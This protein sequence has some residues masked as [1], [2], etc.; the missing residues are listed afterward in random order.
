MDIP[1]R[2]VVTVLVMAATITAGAAFID[3]LGREA[4]AANLRA[5]AGHLAGEVRRLSG[6][7]PFSAVEVS[8]RLEGVGFASIEYLDVGCGPV[9]G[10]ACTALRG[11]LEGG[12]EEWF[13][14]HDS[15]GR[16][17]RLVV[18]T[19]AAIVRLTEGAHVLLL[20]KSDRPTGDILVESRR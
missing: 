19:G 15:A 10:T 17:V 18:A 1:F 3:R 13:Y 16:D 8:L 5:E 14:V 12:R 20:T 9:E 11:R 7:G 4:T 6:L 2:L